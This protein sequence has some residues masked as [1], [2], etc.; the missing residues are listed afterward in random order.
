MATGSKYCGLCG[1]VH[2]ARARTCVCVV[3]ADAMR[4]RMRCR[5]LYAA[6]ACTPHCRCHRL[7]KDSFI[8]FALRGVQW[9]LEMHAR[10]LS[11]ILGDEMG[12]GKTVQTIA[13]LAH[14][15]VRPSR[16]RTPPHAAARPHAAACRRTP[17]FARHG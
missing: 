11:A 16:R 12:L 6:H 7:W 1:C 14:L 17:C 4:A 5:C 3:R 13:F 10:G 15:Q 2:A 8:D 9:L